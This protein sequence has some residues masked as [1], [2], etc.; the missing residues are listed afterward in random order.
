MSKH[1]RL[2]I[3]ESEGIDA[4]VDRFAPISTSNGGYPEVS[5]LKLYYIITLSSQRIVLPRKHRLGRHLLVD[6][7]TDRL[8][9]KKELKK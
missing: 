6:S 3:V 7:V 8:E 4:I 2:S 5:T 1:S 9:R